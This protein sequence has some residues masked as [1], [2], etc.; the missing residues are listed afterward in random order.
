M[1]S[2]PQ[3]IGTAPAMAGLG[4]C[5][6]FLGRPECLHPYRWV[7]TGHRGSQDLAYRFAT[8]RSDRSYRVVR[9]IP[10]VL[11]APGA[12]RVLRAA[13][14]SL[15][16]LGCAW[17]VHLQGCWTTGST[18]DG[19]GATGGNH[20]V[21]DAVESA[22]WQHLRATGALDF[23]SSPSVWSAAVVFTQP[24]GHVSSGSSRV[25]GRIGQTLGDRKVDGGFCIPVV[26]VGE[27]YVQVD[28]NVGSAGHRRQCGIESTVIEYRGVDAA[29]QLTELG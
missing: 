28:R 17:H 29:G 4:R 26:P 20:P 8:W 25:L 23:D 5:A 1:R 12:G 27:A 21:G 2:V 14:R 10:G 24:D 6:V 11:N 7:A 19:D 16:K 9:Q 15:H 13:A 3:R 18:V 22:T